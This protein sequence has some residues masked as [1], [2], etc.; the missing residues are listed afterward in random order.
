MKYFHGFSFS[1]EEEIFNQYLIQS[2]Y[3]VAGFSFGAQQALE[4]VY[5]S[6]KRIEKLILLS[7]AFFQTRKPSFMRTQLR[8]F[9]ADKHAYIKQFVANVTSPS[10][11]DF[12]SYLNVGKK[13]ELEALLSYIWD[14]DKLKEIQNRGTIIEVFLGKKDK[15]IDCKEAFNFFSTLTITYLLKNVGHALQP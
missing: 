12:S 5:N 13:E 10:K 9:S 6:K 14:E 2:D 7:P 11:M 3:C 15:I 1:E 4:Y 8:Y